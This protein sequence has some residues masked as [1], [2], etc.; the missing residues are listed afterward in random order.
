[1]SHEVGP[2]LAVGQVP[3]LHELVPATRNDDGSGGV[4]RESHAADPLG[5]PLLVDGVLALSKGVPQLD[6]LIARTRHDLSVICREGN[7]EDVLG[8][9][10]KSAGGGASVQIPQAEGTVP[11]SRQSKLPVGGDH[12]ILNK[13]GVASQVRPRIIRNR[14]PTKSL[15]GSSVVLL[16]LSCDVPQHDGL[17]CNLE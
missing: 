1:M 5:V 14:L 15:L 6:G 3:H 9:A 13:V 7:A 10:N 12:Q 2:Q 8:V 17:V 16:A 11:G 4:G